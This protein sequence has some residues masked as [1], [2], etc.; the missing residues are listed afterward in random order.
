MKR[1]AGNGKKDEKWNGI[2][3]DDEGKEAV[4]DESKAFP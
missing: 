4:V 3:D 1:K 2:D